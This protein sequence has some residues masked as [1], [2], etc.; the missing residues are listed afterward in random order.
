MSSG[1]RRGALR[2]PALVRRWLSARELV[3]MTLIAVVAGGLWVFVVVAG[4]IGDGDVR[5]LDEAVLLAMRTPGDHA[6][7]R[8][9]RWVEEVGRDLTALGGVTLVTLLSAAAAGFLWLTGRRRA[10]WHLAVAVLG[11]QLLSLS[12]KHGFDRPRPDLVPHASIVYT[13]SFP[14]GHAMMSAVTYLTLGALLARV[15]VRRREKLFVVGWALAFTALTGVSRV[16]VGVHWPSDVVAG[17]AL[18]AAW[19]V[20]CWLV[21]DLLARRRSGVAALPDP[22]GAD[23][24][25]PPDA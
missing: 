18:G 16:Y 12:L 3:T 11:G 9:P 2:W 21:A 22:A 14:S 25:P 7:P 17:W 15:V 10:V 6:D 13:A 20:A 24:R 1:W 19:A 5:A 23:T 8:G 4:A